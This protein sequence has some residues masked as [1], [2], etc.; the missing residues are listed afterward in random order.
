MHKKF[1]FL[2]FGIVKKQ[3][4]KYF[5]DKPLLKNLKIIAKIVENRK[6]CIYVNHVFILY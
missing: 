2:I 3:L 1:F 6:K 4:F 5:I